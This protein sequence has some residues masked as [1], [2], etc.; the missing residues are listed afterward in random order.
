MDIYETGEPTERPEMIEA[1]A[2]VRTTAAEA[3]H[4]WL[5]EAW[6]HGEVIADGNGEYLEPKPAAMD[7]FATTNSTLAISLETPGLTLT[8]EE[9]YQ[10][11]RCL[12]SLDRYCHA[13]RVARSV[14]LVLQ[15]ETS[16]RVEATLQVLFTPL[17]EHV[18]CQ[19]AAETLADAVRLAVADVER[20]L[21]WRAS[22]T[23]QQSDDGTASPRAFPL[24]SS[25][26]ASGEPEVDAEATAATEPG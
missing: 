11:S 2:R 5:D 26:G 18:V 9:R 6:R 10:I 24:G 13:G 20:R 4:Q 21:D 14:A 23:D 1:D 15:R 19:H 7:R 8:A 3:V 17:G 22:P 25:P 12:R 16:W